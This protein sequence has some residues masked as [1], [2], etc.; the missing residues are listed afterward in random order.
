MLDSM[1]LPG[2][3]ALASAPT[4]SKPLGTPV[5]TVKSS[6]SL[7]R[8]TPVPGGMNAAPNQV[9]MLSV[10]A[11]R[12]PLRSSTEK[13]VVLVPATGSGRI[14]DS[15][16]LGVARSSRIDMRWPSA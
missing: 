14:P 5:L 11:T 13:C 4:R 16:T 7:F 8:I 3:M 10:P 2:S 1:R 9:L 6:I 12:F 15:C